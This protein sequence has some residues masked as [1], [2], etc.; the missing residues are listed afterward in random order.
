M[1]DKRK[2]TYRDNKKMRTYR[3]SEATIGRLRELAKATGLTMTRVL[4]DLIH[5][6]EVDDEF[7]TK[8]S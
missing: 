2:A 5:S 3:F 1:I 8:G 6:A 7:E 4:E